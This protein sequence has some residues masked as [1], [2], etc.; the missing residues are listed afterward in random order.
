MAC[1]LRAMSFDS[2]YNNNNNNNPRDQVLWRSIGYLQGKRNS[3]RLLCSW[4]EEEKGIGL[5]QRA[6]RK[7]CCSSLVCF[8]RHLQGGQSP[9]KTLYHTDGLGIRQG[10]PRHTRIQPRKGS[11]SDIR[12]WW[13]P[14]NLKMWNLA[15]FVLS[16]GEAV[17]AAR[18]D[19][20]LN[21]SQELA[22]KAQIP[23]PIETGHCIPETYTC[24]H[25]FLRSYAWKLNLTSQQI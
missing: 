11:F 9:F 13:P 14:Q 3:S 18:M 17:F 8:D 7:L 21:L 12:A 15:V 6:Q 25:S 5:G 4:T 2:R 24:F 23:Y 10:T 16:Y 19:N 20:L 22:P 1:G